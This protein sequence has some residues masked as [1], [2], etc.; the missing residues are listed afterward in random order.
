VPKHVEEKLLTLEQSHPGTLKADVLKVLHH[1]SE[2]TSTHEY[3]AVVDPQ[4]VIISASTRHKLPK[5]TTVL[6]YESPSRQIFRTDDTRASGID[7]IL[8]FKS[9]DAIDCNFADVFVD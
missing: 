4:F 6:R 9:G 8:C 1:G 2:T 5:P 7:H 3:I